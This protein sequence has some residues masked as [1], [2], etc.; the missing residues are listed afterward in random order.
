MS[1]HVVKQTLSG[2]IQNI[3]TKIK[4]YIKRRT[5]FAALCK[6]LQLPWRLKRKSVLLLRQTRAPNITVWLPPTN[7]TLLLK[8]KLLLPLP[9]DELLVSFGTQ[10]KVTRNTANMC[11]DWILYFCESTSM[12]VDLVQA[13]DIFTARRYVWDTSSSI[14]IRRTTVCRPPSTMHTC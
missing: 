8:L 9:G 6:S 1:F 10:R 5:V 11:N 3:E 4:S 7:G 12:T 2:H 13:T 14:W